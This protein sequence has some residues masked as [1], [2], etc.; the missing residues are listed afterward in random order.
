VSIRAGFTD[1][2]LIAFLALERS[3]WRSAVW[4]DWRGAQRWVL[5]RRGKTA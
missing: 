3:E 2:E 5:H 1:E 4:H